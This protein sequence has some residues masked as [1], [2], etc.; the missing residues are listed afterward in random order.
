M[1]RAR[2][3]VG[4][5]PRRIAGRLVGGRQVT[6][7]LGIIGVETAASFEQRERIERSVRGDIGERDAL[8]VVGA[9]G[10]GERGRKDRTEESENQEREQR[11]AS[12]KRVVH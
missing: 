11:A 4:L 10:A 5:R 7:E 6:G 2:R 8:F 12:G 9:G 3:Y 1:I